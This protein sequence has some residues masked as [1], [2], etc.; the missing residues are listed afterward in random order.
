MNNN[1]LASR[2]SVLP[3]GSLLILDKHRAQWEFIEALVQIIVKQQQEIDE[4]RNEVKCLQDQLKLDSH[5]SSKPPSTDQGRA[6]GEK[7]VS[8][9]NKSGKK[10]GGQEG[11]SG[12]TLQAVSNPDRIVPHEVRVCSCCGKDL[13]LIPVGEME[14]RQVFDIPS[15]KLE[16]TEHQSE[17][18][19]C[20]GCHI[21]NRGEFPAGVSQPVQYGERVKGF[22]V[23]LNQ[24]Q[25][26]PY[27][28]VTETFED[29]FER[30]IS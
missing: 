26:I 23:Y 13:S 27:Q 15:L 3:V 28:R 14:K 18:K 4:L 6:S 29:L 16:V 24:Y 5:N 19:I 17:V 1:E 8:L 12:T 30:P 2:I 25:L 7:V 20:P 10:P 21:T 9:R 22:A 11:H